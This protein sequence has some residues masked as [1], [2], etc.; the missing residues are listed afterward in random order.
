MHFL[1]LLFLI[2]LSAAA[3]DQAPIRVVCVGDSITEGYGVG[4]SQ[5]YPVRLQELLGAGYAVKNCGMSGRTISSK[6]DSPYITLNLWKEAKDF[7]PQIAVIMLGSNDAKGANLVHAAGL[8]GDLA[9][10]VKELQSLT[11]KP[12]VVLCL[13]CVVLGAGN[14]DIN[15]GRLLQAVIPAVQE[16]AKDLKLPLIDIHGVTKAAT[17]KDPS[18]IPDLVH[19]NGAGYTLIAETVRDALIKLGQAD[20][21]YK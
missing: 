3:A 20:S 15:E 5:A 19:P 7:Q 17:D 12:Q 4:A 13:P 6:S 9:A 1:S 21:K 10:M 2:S 8:A 18:L 16:V 14:F 11:S